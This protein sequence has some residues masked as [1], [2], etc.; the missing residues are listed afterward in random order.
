VPPGAVLALL[1]VTSTTTV[2]VT[3]RL[4]WEEVPL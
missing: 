4:L 2:S 1:N 3:G